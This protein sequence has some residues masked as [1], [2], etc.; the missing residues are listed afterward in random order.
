MME[1]YMRERLRMGEGGEEVSAWWAN[2]KVTVVKMEELQA[3]DSSKRPSDSMPIFTFAQLQL[4]LDMPNHG[5]E[6][7]D[8]ST[9]R[10]RI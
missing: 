10:F 3:R 6:A 8:F 2:P 4:Q 7:F 9:E 5:I 1:G